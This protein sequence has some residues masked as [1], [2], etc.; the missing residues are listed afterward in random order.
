MRRVK[1][2]LDF[3]TK[4]EVDLKRAGAQRYARHPSTEVLCLSYAFGDEEP[5]IWR[6]GMPKPVD[7]FEAIAEG[8]WFE[9][10]NA[11]FE[12]AIWHHVCVL[13]MG[14]AP[15]PFD[16]WRDTQAV[17][18][19]RAIPLALERAA[20]VLRLPEQK[21][22]VGGKVQKSASKP[23]K[24][25]AAEKKEWRKTHDDY[26]PQPVLWRDDETTLSTTESYCKQDVR[27]ERALS[28][29]VGELPAGE[30]AVWRLDAII[31]D[32]GVQIDVP[33]VQK[34]VVLV[35]QLE[36]MHLKEV[37]ALT[38]GIAPTQIEKFK[39]WLRKNDTDLP[40]MQ[41]DTVTLA[42]KDATFG[43]PKTRRALELRQLLAKAGTKKLQA[44]LDCVCD[45][46]RARG[47]L[48]YH[49]A[50]TG[51][52]AGRLIQPQNFKRPWWAEIDDEGDANEFAANL[53]DA[54][55]VGD[56]DLLTTIY[57]SPIDAL[58]HALRSYLTAG[59][60]NHLVAGD[61][62]AIEAIVTAAMSGE[63]RKLDVFRRKEDP[64]CVFASSVFGVTVTKAD[65]PKRTVGKMGELAFGYGGGIGAWRN[66]EPAGP[67]VHTDEDITRYRDA[68]RAL[69]P[70]IN[71]GWAG[72]EQ[73]AV[74]TV[75]TGRPHSWRQV[76]YFM[77][78]D[79]DWLGCR[80]P[81]GRCIW[82]R[83]P[84]IV[85][86][87]VPWDATDFRP[88]LEYK[89]W[90]PAKGGWVVIRAWGGHLMENVVQGTARCLMVASMFR[91]EKAGLP[92]VLTCHDEL[93]TDVPEA[94][95]DARALEQIMAEL[96]PWAAKWPVRAEAFA[97]FRYRK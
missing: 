57:G 94:R 97:G 35:E 66:F 37:R 62:S 39:A 56:A 13:R 33:S 71:A 50:G 27:T 1:L 82:Y 23:R 14:W 44:M 68:W 61:F 64:Y 96:P 89:A 69:H 36:A 32:R 54:I 78:S 29:V 74:N 10:H 40:N 41:D 38:G 58:S 15:V 72:L 17:C 6:P 95:A 65:K 8:C 93:V 19:Y 52:W 63:E 59:P 79:G 55:N 87:A 73:A 3:E 60:G 30:L 53:I 92:I 21:D 7:L 46:G 12:R 85:E 16:L 84:R 75:L 25:N 22:T 18:A 11:A 90:K 28:K 81:S 67:S 4:S 43:T 2:T 47:L 31:N 80:L 91:A 45:D 24:M 83:E 42:L 9:A 86:R 5:R 26:E 49:G 70:A 51:R 20:L 88:C 48:Q 34:A 77:A 76:E